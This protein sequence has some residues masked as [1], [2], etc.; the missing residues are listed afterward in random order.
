MANYA[1]SNGISIEAGGRNAGRMTAVPK[2]GEGDHSV[3]TDPTEARV[4]SNQPS[5]C[6]GDCYRHGARGAQS[7]PKLDFERLKENHDTPRSH[8]GGSDFG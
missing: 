6:A 1:H 8:A 7:K 2:G 3:L 4:L 5:E